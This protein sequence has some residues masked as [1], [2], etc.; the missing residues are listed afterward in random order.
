MEPNIIILSEPFHGLDIKSMKKLAGNL[1]T[2]AKKDKTILILTK[3]ESN[4]VY[5]TLFNTTHLFS[6]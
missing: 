2:L 1:L 6:N 4:E 3:E 5:S